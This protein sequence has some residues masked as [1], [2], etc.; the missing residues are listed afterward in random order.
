LNDITA[1]VLERFNFTAFTLYVFSLIV[2]V[3]LF[4]RLTYLSSGWPV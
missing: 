3:L 1:R 2:Y 4:Y